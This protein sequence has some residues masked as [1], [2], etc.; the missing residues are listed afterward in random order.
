MSFLEIS[1]D[2]YIYTG[3]C[4]LDVLRMNPAC[5]FEPLYIIE[6][7]AKLD[8]KI[9]LKTLKKSN[10]LNNITTAATSMIFLFILD[11]I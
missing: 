10:Y 3:C 9:V 7:L 11:K 2:K 6:A 8:K 5:H 4:G 1:V